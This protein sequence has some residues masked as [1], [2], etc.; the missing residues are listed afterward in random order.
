[1]LKYHASLY[2]A[3]HVFITLLLLNLFKTTLMKRD[4]VEHFKSL[5]CIHKQ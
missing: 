4:K 2:K 5:V 3:S 1:M